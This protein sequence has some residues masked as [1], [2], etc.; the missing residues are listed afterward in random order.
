ML[1]V[2][3]QAGGESRRMG[4]DKALLPFL[5]QPLIV[6][7]LNRVAGIAD[8]LLITANQPENYRFLGL[9]PIP[10][11]QPG[12]GALGGLYTALDAAHHLAVAVVGCDM[13]F[14]NPL[15]LVIELQLLNETGADL[16]IPHGADGL[17]PFHAVY[18]R[19]TCLPHVQRA[20]GA[21]LRRVD[22]WFP[23]VKVH[24]LAPEDIRP[25]DPLGLAFLNVNTPEELKHAEALAGGV[26]G[27]GSSSRH[28]PQADRAVG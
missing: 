26:S 15:L 28:S 10:D 3:I 12:A 23:Q 13:P 9:T 4:Q 18:R 22:A 8:E 14:V 21:G 25:Y 6:R 20:L 5:G 19:E 7:A 1:T 27:G 11:R 17:E 16:V 2:A 24:E